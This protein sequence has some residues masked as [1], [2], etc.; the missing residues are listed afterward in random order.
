VSQRPERT[1]TRNGL[2]IGFLSPSLSRDAGG[3]AEVERRLAQS[4]AQLPNVKVEVFGTWDTAFGQDAALWPPIPVYAHKYHGPQQFRW[5][6]ALGRAFANCSADVAHLHVLWMHTSFVMRNWAKRTG[7]PFVTTLHGMLDPWALRNSRWKKR[8]SELAYE[9]D[10]LARAACIHVFS[11]AELAS[12]RAFGLTNPIC[13]I[14]NGVDLPQPSA[15]GAP[16]NI[17]FRRGRRVLLYLGR[18]HPKKG[19]AVLLQAWKELSTSHFA[20]TR[21]WCIVIAGWNQ[22]A[23]QSQLASLAATLG[24]ESDV[25]FAGPLFGEA[26]DAAYE[27]ADA[28]VLPSFSEG[29]PMV[30]LE[31]WS[32]AKSVLMTPQCNIP[33]GFS[34]GAALSA[35]PT[36]TGVAEGLKK[37]LSAS[38]GQ[39]REMGARGH[40]LIQHRFTWP[41]VA[42]EMYSVYSWLVGGGDP[43]TCVVRE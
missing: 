17:E 14:P 37:L 15:A 20:P 2:S 31:A 33:E 43:P 10:C 27:H 22:N 21:D 32:H 19:L 12:A 35:E 1:A 29:L 18:L 39:R 3:I 40:E 23:H 5:S 6:P 8:I 26:K 7:K 11:S 28:V 38:E 24:I 25:F 41:R 30:I 13:V 34:A 16:W 4:L 42:A 9:R 36:V